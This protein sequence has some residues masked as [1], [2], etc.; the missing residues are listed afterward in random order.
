MYELERYFPSLSQDRILAMT[1]QQTNY[2]LEAMERLKAKERLE[3]MDA[4]IYP[5]MNRKD[6]KKKHRK[7]YKLAYPE[8]FNLENI[9]KK[10]TELKLI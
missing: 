8:N 1:P 3:L 2:Y 7:L 6:M 4:L 5:N 9:Q 10:T